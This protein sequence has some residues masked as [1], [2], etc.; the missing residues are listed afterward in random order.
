[1]K[2]MYGNYNN[3]NYGYSGWG[4][5]SSGFT[6]SDMIEA[7]GGSK[8]GLADSY[9]NS[10][11][12]SKK[13][14]NTAAIGGLAASAL[15]FG[16]GKIAG[17]GALGTSMAST[18]GITLGAAATPIL[19]L[20]AVA[21]AGALGAFAITK[22]IPSLVNGAGQLSSVACKTI[23]GIFDKKSSNAIEK[24][25]E[26]FSEKAVTKSSELDKKNALI[27]E[28]EAKFTKIL[29][30]SKSFF[31]ETNSAKT[32]S[33]LKDLY[34]LKIPSQ[35]SKR[36]LHNFTSDYFIKSNTKVDNGAKILDVKN[37]KRSV[38]E[39]AKDLKLSRADKKEL[40]SAFL[41]R[42]EQK[43]DN[44]ELHVDN[45]FRNPTTQRPQEKVEVKISANK[46][47]AVAIA[48]K[49]QQATK[50]IE[51]KKSIE[52]SKDAQPK[53]ATPTKKANHSSVKSKGNSGK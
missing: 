49:A 23:G 46:Q 5:N 37:A 27:Q 35:K 42:V 13:D 12:L 52:N 47:K 39:F 33:A 36:E 21:G 1:M 14:E 45:R 10:I 40:E 19:G 44:F 16:T 25:H 41:N 50:R 7:W 28:R 4:S 17:L 26:T 18:L 2:S 15:A 29:Q 3:N 43:K 53:A 48:K 38:G 11:G 51:S 32:N 20:A 34:S 6:P 31:D 8:R 24:T 9:V 30:E 22:G